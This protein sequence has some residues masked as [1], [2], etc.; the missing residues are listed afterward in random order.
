MATQGG[1]Q[2]GYALW[3]QPESTLGQLV[4]DYGSQ[5]YV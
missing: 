4:I 3:H 1:A 5:N 2:E